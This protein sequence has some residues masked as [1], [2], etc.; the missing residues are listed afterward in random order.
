MAKQTFFVDPLDYRNKV[1]P[2]ILRM[3]GELLNVHSGGTRK[4]EVYNIG[5]KWKTT[6]FYDGYKALTLG[7]TI[8][9]VRKVRSRLE[10]LSETKLTE[11]A[12]N[13]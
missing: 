12:Q 10:K 6:A 1:R 3:G 4:I 9:S 7:S 8:V 5:R 2:A 11:I 13:G